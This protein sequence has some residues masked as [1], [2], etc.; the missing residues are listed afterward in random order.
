MKIKKIKKLST[1]KYRLEM[2]RGEKITTYD[3]VILKYNLLFGHEIDADLY[4]KIVSE[5]TAYDNFNKAVKQISVKLRSTYEI[6][7][8]LEKLELTK[9]EQNR[10]L[11]E[12]TEKGLLNDKRYTQAY[13]SD[14]IH[15][16]SD[17]PYKIKKTLLDNQIDEAIIDDCLAHYEDAIFIDKLKSRIKKRQLQNKSSISLFK[18]KLKAEFLYLGY[19]SD[20]IEQ[21]F[22][23]S[24]FQN[25]NLAKE[26]EKIKNRLIKKYEGS[27]LEMQLKNKLYQK[28]YSMTEINDYLKN[29][30]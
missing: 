29:Q 4:S 15:L 21:A 24:S 25:N 17:G 6:K 5:T 23:L 30:N 22:E 16:S 20:Q 28:G 2:E 11:T 7:K 14:R 10:I 3:E 1:N 13:I 19:S 9:E 8:Y 18:Q 26:A 12:L 27:T